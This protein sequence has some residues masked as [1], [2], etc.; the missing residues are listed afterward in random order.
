MIIGNAA[1]ERQEKTVV[2][3]GTNNRRFTVG[4]SNDSS[5]VNGNAM[6]VKTLERCFNERID[7]EMSNIV[8]T[9][10]DRIQNA[11][12]TAIENIV[13]PKIELAIRSIN[14]SSGRDA[15]SVSANSERREHVG[16]STSFEN[17]SGNN[18]TLGVS[19]VNGETRQN[20]RY[21]VSELSVSETRFDRQA[22]T[23][24]MVTGQTAQTNQFPEFLTGRILT[25]R[26]PPSHQYQ[27]LS[28]QVSQD[29]NLPAVEQTPRNQNSDPN[30]YINRLADAIA[31]IAT[32][33]R[34][35]AATMLKP[36]STNTLIFDGKNEK[37]ELFEDL[38]QTMLKT[39]SEMTKA[40]KINHFDAHLRKEA[41]QT[42]KNISALNKKT[43]DDVLFVFRRKYVKPESQATAKHKW[44]KLTFN[45]N[46]KSLP[47]FLEELNECAERAF[48]DNAQHM[49]DSLLYAKLPPHL[50]RSLNLA[51]LEK[52]SYD[53]VV[54]HL[55]RELELSG[56]ENDGE[57]TIPTMT[58]VPP[59]DNQQNTEQTKVVSHYCKSQAT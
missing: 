35:Q 41:L 29:N 53:Q 22:H 23:H 54:A 16:I 7:K 48:G 19:N 39:Q 2:N 25:P 50:K 15:T 27:N 17:A 49:I 46:T 55:E 52:G 59:N 8:D 21:E 57:L 28:T 43:L 38:F 5:I 32:Q 30:N 45:P 34:P 13:A 24:H 18:D 47:D 11:I 42:F 37:Y 26:N 58:A 6:S 4:S 20:I 31:G 1:S 44:H 12:L 9:V 40:M 14:A 36:V 10:E 3:E 33:Q 56:L 51:Y